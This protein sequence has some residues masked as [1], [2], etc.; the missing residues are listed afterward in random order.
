MRA[1]PHRRVRH[2]GPLR[3]RRDDRFLG[4]VAGMLSGRTGID[5]T[6]VRVGLVIFGLASG[7]GVAAYVVAWL[8]IP[9]EDEPESIGSRA[10]GDG[11]GLALAAGLIPVLIVAL[12]VASTL[13]DGW[14]ASVTWPAFASAF[15]LVLI[16]RNASDDER[17]MWRRATV[18]LA[19]IGQG[20]LRSWRGLAL[21]ILLGVILLAAGVTILT[22]GHR[23]SAGLQLT[24]VALVLAA[25]VVVFG[26]WW[27]SV[28]REL[29]LERQG[30]LVAEERADLAARV[31]DSVLQTLA[32]IQRHAD[33]PQ[34]VAQLARAQER[35]LRS[36]LF[37]GQPPGS[38]ADGVTT[39]SAAV[40]RIQSDVEAAHGVK[41]DAV[42]VGDG[43]L[44]DEIEALLAAGREATVNAAKWSG[45]DVVSLFAEVEPDRVSLFV[46]DRGKGFERDSVASDRRGIA[47]SI[48]GRMAR[49]G[50]VAVIRTQ[51]GEGTEV[52]L[53]VPRRD[54]SAAGRRGPR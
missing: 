20:G 43:P 1:H 35:E 44:T 24:G 54:A 28:A 51:L 32:M 36:W 48:E 52:E 26:P 53:S 27:L 34:R 6:F 8:V 50:G 40:R 31:H 7:I 11:R 13:G 3:R 17:V 42:V 39:V 16:W 19:Q 41:V 47:E 10:V 23:S 18:P 45:A 4:G 33:E 2:R 25:V 37:E 5:V 46:R 14:L 15:G 22:V 30:R 29:V 49:S 12:L 38:F 9:F 21:R